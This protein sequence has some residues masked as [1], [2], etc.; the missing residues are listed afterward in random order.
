MSSAPQA[1][2]A[3]KAAR[4]KRPWRDNLEAFGIALLFAV[5]L[6]PMIIE[7]Y[8]IP[9]PSMQPTL[10]GSTEAGIHDRIL[11]DKQRYEILDPK[12]WDIVVFRYPIRRNQN[13]VKRIV[14]VPGDRLRIAGGNLYQVGED[15]AI[16]EV[17]RKPDHI[18]AGLWKE[19]FPARYELEAAKSEPRLL[20]EFFQGQAGKW[21]EEDGDLVVTPSSSGRAR[22]MFTDLGHNG[23][24]NQV[25][26]GYPTDVAAAIRE[27]AGG[28]RVEGVQDI[29]AS[30]DLSSTGTLDEL[31]V[32]LSLRPNGQDD[33]ILRMV[34]AGG[35]ARLTITVGGKE[36]AAS[37]PISCALPSNGS[38]H[39]SFAHIDDL[40]IAQR[41]GTEIAR[42]DVGEHRVARELAA[43]AVTLAIQTRGKSQQRLG[44]LVV[45]RDLHY[46]QHGLDDAL[47]VLVPDGL[48]LSLD[49]HVIEIPEGQYFMMGDNTLRSA[50][51]RQWKTFAV[52]VDEDGQL[53]DPETH[54][55]ARVLEGNKRPWPL[56]SKPDNDENPVVVR[57]GSPSTPDDIVFTD[58][59]GEVHALSGKIGPNYSEHGMQ[60][61]D[62][63]GNGTRAW[64]PEEEHV[65][66]VPREHI[67]G[68][69]LLTFWPPSRIGII[70]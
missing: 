10:M 1:P 47:D 38:A 62:G 56:A 14:G 61:T 58:D 26:D 57:S 23:L 46:T 63:M 68:R 34:V 31:T 22:L 50:D 17:L 35:N 13:Y 69:P 19:V 33:R 45:E 18:Q 49:H 24:C 64:T 5:L 67:L 20:G 66:F 8:Q 51:A 40:L 6:K 70:R 41:D 16:G 65:F 55:N 52:A 43:R 4:P 37:D 39:F 25:Y 2:A 11:V 48:D 32:E 42:L 7:A 53:V 30:F 15:G 27:S 21:T 3:D 54:P 28:D 29:R 60:F 9:T 59:N 36:V 44:D 12:R